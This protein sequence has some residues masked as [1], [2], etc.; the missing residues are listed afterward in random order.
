MA[1]STMTEIS[2]LE[3]LLPT[4]KKWGRAE[5]LNEVTVQNRTLPI[6]GLTLGSE[7]KTKP[8]FGLFGGVHGLERVGSH[9]VINFISSLCSQLEWD[10]TL[11]NL[12]QEFRFV[13]IPII[14]PGGFFLNTRSNPH[15][16][17]IMR[18]AEVEAHGAL[19]PF[20]S[21]HRISPK[22]PWFR[23]HENSP[24]EIETQT[25]MRFVENEMLSS[26]FSMALDVHSG[27]GMIDRLWY[28]FSG[29]AER[30]TYQEHIDKFEKLLA[31]SQPFHIY[32]VEPQH[33]S[34][35][36]HGDPWDALFSAHQKNY[37][38]NGSIFIP[39]CLEMGSWTWLKKNPIQLFTKGGLFNPILPHRYGRI[40]RRHRPLLDFFKQAIIH[41]ENWIH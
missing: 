38:Q 34:Y 10:K 20:V 29:S 14:N 33:A 17:D 8:T 37:A 26:Q 5:R 7:D 22:L 25:L 21:G 24:L 31:Q 13:S 36:I 35:L 11:Q 18:N 4:F 16:V 23:G 1:L 40:M 2:M 6:Y 9:V 19:K 12:F 27:F 15:G 39:W 3:S 32:K 30:F 28:P 41:H